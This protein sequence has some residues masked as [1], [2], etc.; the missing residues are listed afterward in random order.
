[1]RRCKP[2]R[3][4]RHVHQLG[5]GRLAAAA[6]G[7]AVQVAPIKPKLKPPGTERLRL[8]IDIL[9]STSAFKINL[10][11]YRWV[12]LGTDDIMNM[13]GHPT[14]DLIS[15]LKQYLVSFFWVTAT[16]STNGQGRTLVHVR[17]RLEQLQDTFMS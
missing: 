16:I 3:V 11:R 17:A 10:R 14:S 1:M 6:V 8:N 9:L 5:D 4:G 12:G 7:G 13:E 15:V 2:L